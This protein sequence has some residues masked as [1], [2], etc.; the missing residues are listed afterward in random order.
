MPRRYHRAAVLRGEHT[1]LAVLRGEHT[2]L[3]VTL[4][5]VNTLVTCMS[6][7][8]AGI[9]CVPRLARVCTVRSSVTH[10]GF[11][12]ACKL[13]KKHVFVVVRTQCV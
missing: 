9:Y 2:Y 8:L 4:L 12:F 7:M 10:K 11:S 1:Y 5:P 6:L 13:A 3:R